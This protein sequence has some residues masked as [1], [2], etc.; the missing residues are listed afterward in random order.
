MNMWNEYI[1]VQNTSGQNF[2][3]MNSER[4]EI[5]HKL[6]IAQVK[7]RHWSG[8]LTAI[9]VLGKFF[10][11]KR[12]FLRNFFLF[13]FDNEY[14]KFLWE[15]DQIL[16]WIIWT[17]FWYDCRS[18]R[19]SFVFWKRNPPNEVSFECIYMLGMWKCYETII[20]S[21]FSAFPLQ[22]LHR[23]VRSLAAFSLLK[24][25]ERCDMIIPQLIM[26]ICTVIIPVFT[27]LTDLIGFIMAILSQ[28]R[29]F[30]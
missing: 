16:L 15:F 14:G 4:K 28:Y 9:S 2:I 22:S 1:T 13:R 30:Q 10:C 20:M 19:D 18:N 24:S 11:L 6:E 3:I 25:L 29:D 21:P 26:L 17:I 27:I 8:W 7:L 12:N 23:S 5:N